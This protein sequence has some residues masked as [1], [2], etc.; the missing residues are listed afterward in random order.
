MPEYTSGQP[1]DPSG[2]LGDI[3]A[4]RHNSAELAQA[5]GAGGVFGPGDIS[6]TSPSG[7]E[8]FFRDL[9]R[10]RDRAE[11]LLLFYFAG[12]GLVSSFNEPDELWL[13]MPGTTI[14]PGSPPAFLGAVRWS[15]MLPVLCRAKARQ[16]VVVLDCCYAGNASAAWN[17]LPAADRQRL[18]L[19][20][21]V[22]A[23]DRIDAGDGETPTPFTAQLVRLLEEGVDEDGGEVRFSTLADALRVRMSRH[24]TLRQEPN[25]W[26]PHSCPADGADVVLAVAPR[27]GAAPGAA[28]PGPGSDVTPEDPPAG[29]GAT[30]DPG[31]AAG[32]GPSGAPGRADDPGPTADPERADDPD[33]AADPGRA[34][35]PVPLPG[36]PRRL[37][38][39]VALALILAVL[40]WA[41]W[42][43]LAGP[44]DLAVCAPP[45]ELRLLTDPDAE[46]TVRRAADA[47]L[48]S[49]ANRTR[50]CRHTGITV[51]SAKATDTVAAFRHASRFWQD[52]DSGTNPQRDVGPQPDIWIPGSTATVERALSYDGG[53]SAARL[54]S[55]PAFVHSPMV[56]AVPAH[57]AEAKEADRTGQPLARFLDALR[58]RDPAAAVARTDPEYTDSALLA[59]VGLYAGRPGAASATERRLAPGRPARD[60]R[61]LLCELPEDAAADTRTAALVPEH[62]LRT[63]VGCARQT[64]MARVAHYP[65][66]VPRLA[67]P[68][69]HVAWVGADRDRDA[70]TQAV[71][72]FRAWLTGPDGL[73]VFTADGYRA[74]P[75]DGGAPATAP[76]PGGSPP[77]AGALADPGTL[78][79]TAHA[80][81]VTDA[82]DGYRRA[83]GP[84][85]VLFLLDS[86][87]SM[88]NLWHGPSGAPG[89]VQQALDGLGGQDRYGVW[90]VAAPPGAA[91]P[92]TPLL[93]L[94]THPRRDEARRTVGT[95]RVL[96][97]EADP[98]RALRAA[99]DALRP[100]AGDDDGPRLIVLVTDDEDNGHLTAD[101]RLPEL[102]SALSRAGIP[103][104][105]ASLDVGCARGGPDVRIAAAS[106]GRCLD[107]SDELVAGLRDEV[108]RAGTGETA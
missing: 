55:H 57:L 99:L 79:A 38:G 47:Y 35:G 52:P 8:A 40:V 88:R 49:G 67:L 77:A 51:H 68:F 72:R 102:T 105:V 89:I 43:E 53:G 60:G 101:G 64:R 34:A 81:T 56:L 29:R 5:L 11:G 19:L 48:A 13:A 71:E 92:Y 4:V 30:A 33:R 95:A 107:S 9:M 39:A 54:R 90:A 18:S 50:G 84:G 26:V 85:R 25:T 14:L 83:N 96:D 59:T 2:V 10:A 104:V 21:C 23:N 62:L 97:H 31:R 65:R 73:A 66:D 78:P 28:A 98:Y 37:A 70:R 86:S 6:T 20:A 76:S 44:A 1:P 61:A 3:A 63:G 80:P 16:V 87:G 45:L 36:G 42:R 75:G 7:S 22:Q 32:P 46:P 41:G 93:P 24:T 17:R 27:P 15:D 108:A 58:E 74:G 91:L 103:V 106:G 82:L 12:H 69:V 100:A 94:G